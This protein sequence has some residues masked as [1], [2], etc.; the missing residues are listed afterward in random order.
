MI[1]LND[2]Q[3]EFSAIGLF[4]TDNEWIHPKI[5]VKTYELIFVV[6]GEVHITENKTEYHLKKGDMLL[7]DK[8]TKHYGN[9]KSLGHTSFYWLHFYCNNVKKFF[10]K[11]VYNLD[12]ISTERTMKELSHMFASKKELAELNFAKFILEL[13]IL[14]DY[15]NPC[16]YEIAEFIRINRNKPITVN[17][18]SK[19]FGYNPDHLSKMLKKEFGLDAKTLIIKKRLEFVQSLL[20][21]TDYSL[22]EIS[23]SAGFENQNYFIKFFRYHTGTTP[24]AYRKKYFLLHMNNN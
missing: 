12:T 21:N 20:I 2:C 5:A 13:E 14:S 10:N 15:K 9:K 16:A 3:L 6:N 4:D 23:E 18:L 17:D 7:L 24:S 11:K 1:V 22:K 8:N 19:R